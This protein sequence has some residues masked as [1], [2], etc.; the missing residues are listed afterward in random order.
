MIRR[1]VLNA[2]I[3]KHSQTGYF[4]REGFAGNVYIDKD[5]TEGFTV[6]KIAV[7]GKHPRKRILEGNTR[8]YYVIDGNGHFTIDSDTYEIERGDLCVIPA[9]SEYEYEGD[10][11]L[12][13]FNV[14]PENSFGDE[15]V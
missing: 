9:N 11:T 5:Q 6:L 4:E 14:S 8:S 12:F 2:G 13:E 10:M 1:K 7:H 3:I 15:R